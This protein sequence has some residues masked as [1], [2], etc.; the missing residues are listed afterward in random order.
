[1]RRRPGG[2]REGTHPRTTPAPPPPRGGPGAPAPPGG[3]APPPPPGGPNP[4]RPPP[5][6]VGAA[7]GRDIGGRYLLG[8]GPGDEAE[9]RGE[10]VRPG[11]AGRQQRRNR[12][13]L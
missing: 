5:V 3:R 13:I 4:P 10:G 1:M 2:E 12:G 8:I 6:A 9:H 11:L 7:I